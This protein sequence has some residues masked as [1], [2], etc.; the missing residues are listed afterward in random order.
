[1]KKLSARL[2]KLEAAF[3]ISPE[4]K[5]SMI[6]KGIDEFLDTLDEKTI[7]DL[8]LFYHEIEWHRKEGNKEAEAEVWER[9][10][11]YC[12][13]KE[14]KII[15][16]KRAGW[17]HDVPPNEL[18]FTTTQNPKAPSFEEFNEK[19]FIPGKQVEEG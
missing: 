16:E 14:V 15:D 10:K 1:M 18:P 8:P 19:F 11:R 17:I 9:L 3:N 12:E 13:G 7:N 6:E 5:K 4:Q 2:E